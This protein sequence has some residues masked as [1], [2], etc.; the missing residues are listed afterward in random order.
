MY[1]MLILH[2]IYFIDCSATRLLFIFLYILYSLEYQKIFILPFTL[3]SFYA[4]VIILTYYY[5]KM[6]QHYNHHTHTSVL[7][8]Q[9][10]R[11]PRTTNASGR[12]VIGMLALLQ[13]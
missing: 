10:A 1:H 8:K 12:A 11:E 2:Y 6:E 7:G 3:S 13:R 4:Y 9:C 5:L